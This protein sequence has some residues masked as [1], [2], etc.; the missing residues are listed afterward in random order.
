VF[1]SRVGDKQDL[2]AENQS[3]TRKEGKAQWEKKGRRRREQQER[4]EIIVGG[5]GGGDYESLYN[6]LKLHNGGEGKKQT[7]DKPRPQ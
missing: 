1:P 2:A 5:E 4:K 6:I 7:T 3:A